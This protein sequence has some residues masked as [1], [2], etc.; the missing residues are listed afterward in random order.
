M[1]ARNRSV[2]WY[3]P[4]AGASW[5]HLFTGQVYRGGAAQDVAAPLDELPVFTRQ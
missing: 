5:K 1:G 4:D 3:F 2:Y